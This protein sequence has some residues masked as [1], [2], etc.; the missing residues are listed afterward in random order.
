MERDPTFSAPHPPAPE[1]AVEQLQRLMA[2]HPFAAQALFSA[3]VAEGRRFAQTPEGARL[4]ARLA[5]SPTIQ[6]ARIAWSASTLGM[7]VDAPSTGLPSALV[8]A[9]ARLATAPD[10]E[11]RLSRALEGDH[12]L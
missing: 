3:L 11:A 9:F 2:H 5:S 1:A 4:R 10:L 7:L 8:E 12:G 6:R